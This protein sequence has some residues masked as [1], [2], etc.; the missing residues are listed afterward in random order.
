M[1]LKGD[2]Y[3]RD[4]WGEH[5]TPTQRSHSV[6]AHID[7]LAHHEHQLGW[8]GSSN[9]ARVSRAGPKKIIMSISGPGPGAPQKKH[10]EH[11]R[12]EPRPVPRARIM[13]T[14]GTGPPAKIPHTNNPK[15]PLPLSPVPPS[16][17]PSSPPASPSLSFPLLPAF[18]SPQCITPA[19]DTLFLPSPLPPL[20]CFCLGSRQYLCWWPTPA[21]K[22]REG[23]RTRVLD[24]RCH[25]RQWSRRASARSARSSGT[26][27]AR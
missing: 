24:L 4:S 13:S 2:P 14:S 18:P 22:Q 15:A 8:V 6:P 26:A 20:P 12:L 27:G 11:Q 5:M 17:A 21:R 9:N 23:L 19:S 10:H 7:P 3:P 25:S 1:I 16:P